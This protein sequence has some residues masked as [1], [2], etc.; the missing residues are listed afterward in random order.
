MEG[1]IRAYEQGQ[2]NYEFNDFKLC[3]LMKPNSESIEFYKG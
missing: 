3:K 2:S 1:K